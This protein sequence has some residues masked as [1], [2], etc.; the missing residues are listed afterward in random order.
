M[1]LK[2][3]IKLKSMNFFYK[4]NLFLKNLNYRSNDFFFSQRINKIIDFQWLDN[5]EL[6]NDIPSYLLFSYMNFVL[7][8][9]LFFFCEMKSLFFDKINRLKLFCN[10]LVFVDKKRK[11]TF[12]FCDSSKII[13]S[14]LNNE[15]FIFCNI[16]ILEKE[17]FN[18]QID[19]YSRD[20]LKVLL[21]VLF[22]YNCLNCMIKPFDNDIFVFTRSYFNS[23]TIM[24]KNVDIDRY[25]FKV[26][27]DLKLLR[28]EYF[29]FFLH[30]FLFS[31]IN[32]VINLKIFYFYKNKTFDKKFFFNYKFDIYYYNLFFFFCNPCMYFFF[33]KFLLNV[34][35][36]DYKFF[37]DT[38]NY[39]NINYFDYIYI[40]VYLIFFYDFFV[41]VKKKEYLNIED[42]D[43]LIT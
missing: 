13:S 36:I 15:Q 41:L 28:F 35:I 22:N 1:K 19:I 40:V 5:L 7:K 26:L 33:F 20:L 6:N 3:Y 2:K 8:Y 31:S 23:L 11:L 18:F 27:Y 16:N 30:L 42:N 12:F 43:Y 39:F 24:F 21:Y 37:N 32:E 38:Y 17:L 25:F 14:L 4:K 10:Y 9:K 34:N 29:G